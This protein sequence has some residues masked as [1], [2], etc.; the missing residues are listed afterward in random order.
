MGKLL[1]KIF[2]PNKDEL[3]KKLSEE[4]GAEYIAE[5]T[6]KQGAIKA[7]V[8][9]WTITIDTYTVSTGKSSVTFTRLRAPYINRDGFRFE[10]Y[11]K[12]FLSDMGKLFGMQDVEVG[13]PQFDDLKPLFGVD[14]YLNRKD[15]E[16]GYPEFDR[17]FIIKGNNVEK[18]KMIFKNLRIRELIQDQPDIHLQIKDDEGWFGQE[19]PK[20]VD[21][22][23][24]QVA[25]IITD[26]ERLKKLYMLF[27]EVL[28]FLCHMGSAYEDDPKIDLK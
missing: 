16:A 28:N 1:R 24:F 21:E 19:F 3:W 26:M 6:F 9:N 27:A 18:L 14:S 11:R 17:D 4:I 23:Y 15:V 8:R 5:G 13:A 7:Q 20:G 2:G 12:N 22:I 10:I 25:E